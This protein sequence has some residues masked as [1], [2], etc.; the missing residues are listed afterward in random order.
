MPEILSLFFSKQLFLYCLRP[1]V[2]SFR[3]PKYNQIIK[4]FQTFYITGLQNNKE[5]IVYESKV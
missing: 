1:D 3:R 5:Q 2:D 4:K